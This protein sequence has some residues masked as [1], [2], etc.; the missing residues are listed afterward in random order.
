MTRDEL[1]ED[2]D[3]LD[4][5]GEIPENWP[6]RTGKTASYLMRAMYRVGRVDLARKINYVVNEQ[7]SG[8]AGRRYV[9]RETQRMVV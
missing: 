7:R 8:E 9:P 2:L 1:A 4:R 6:K 5:T 3:W